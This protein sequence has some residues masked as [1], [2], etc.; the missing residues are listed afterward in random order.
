LSISQES[1]KDIRPIVS[2]RVWDSS[3]PF[4]I[5]QRTLLSLETLQLKA[6]PS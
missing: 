5:A 3:L 4:P 2:F 6:G 1:G